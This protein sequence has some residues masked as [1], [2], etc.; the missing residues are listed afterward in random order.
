MR[1][2]V[3]LRRPIFSKTNIREEE[4]EEEEEEEAETEAEAAAAAAAAADVVET[5]LASKS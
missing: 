2:F 1:R 3:R 5:M 4:E